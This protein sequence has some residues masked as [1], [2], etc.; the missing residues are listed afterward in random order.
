MSKDERFRQYAIFLCDTELL[1]KLAGGDLI[2][3][4]AKYHSNCAVMYRNRVRS[5]KREQ[6]T[7]SSRNIRKYEG[8]S[9]F[10]LVSDIEEYRYD[11]H[12]PT[13]ILCNLVK[14]YDSILNNILPEG[15][16]PPSTHSTRLKQKL[17]AEIPDLQFFK[18]GKQGYL[19]FNSKITELL[20]ENFG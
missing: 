13:F 17:L 6:N 2:A 4:E 3:L 18:K 1:S 15:L 16:G 19:A 20:H 11:K 8:M 7:P 9:F 5:K 10:H 14:Q 12:A